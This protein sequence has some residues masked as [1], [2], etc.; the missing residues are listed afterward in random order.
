MR[1]PTA[2]IAVLAAAALAGC[3]GGGGGGAAGDL[4]SSTEM[5]RTVKTQLQEEYATDDPTISVPDVSCVKNEKGARCLAHVNAGDDVSDDIRV[6][7]IRITPS[8]EEKG[9]FLWETEDSP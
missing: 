8:S 5:A 2:I 6:V 9:D 3:G 1:R 7:G 4:P